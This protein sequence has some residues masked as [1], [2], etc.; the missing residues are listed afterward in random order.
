MPSRR[1]LLKAGGVL[2]AATIVPG[3]TATQAEAAS[4]DP[5]RKV[6]DILRKIRPPR[7]PD[8]RWDVTAFGAVG[9]GT[10]DCTAAF[11]AAIAECHR[12]GGGRVV[13][14][15]GRFLTGAIHLLSD[16]E[17][18][19]S[20]GGVIAFSTDP[21][22]YLPVVLTRWESTECYNYSPFIYAYGR[23][24]VAVTGKG[25]LDGQARQ[26]PWESWYA[27]SGPQS[28]DQ[29]ALRKMGDDGV[30]VEQ[31]VFGAGHY[32]RPAMVQFVKC[33]N[34]LVSDVTILEP[35]MW[36]VNPVL[37]RN[38]TV[39]GITV[40]STLYN[41][42][43]CDPEASSYV[44][45]KDCRFNTNDDC[46]AVKSGRDAD[47]RRVGV[48]S[49]N[50]VVQDCYFSGRWGGI[51][52][53]SEMSGGVRNVFAER[54]VINSP[55]FPGNYPVKY[56]VYLKA[57]KKRGAYIEGVYVR[58]FTGGN[59]EREVIFVN[60]AYNNEAGAEPLSVRDIRMERT[61][62]DGAGAVLNLVGLETDHLVDVRLEKCE[63]TNVAGPDKIAFTDGLRLRKV[64]VN[65]V[66]Q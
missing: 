38:V 8:R 23:R 47:G 51:T 57:N 36:T 35:P 9:D 24:N 46:V 54:C 17:L 14:P 1:S 27:N 18:H 33:Q 62:L 60:M 50:I 26:G 44:H 25:T 19:V 37:S 11:K 29:K 22:A 15:P 56:P 63:F 53:G 3:T 31:R 30:P 42:D 45:I 6:P 52:V 10:T 34:I 16:V 61:R 32:L 5:W 4:S 39:R 66:E 13:V 28:A 55:D 40:V 20:E 49:E 43:G 59:V 12:R 2:A 64:F 7:F 65:G 21:N 58:D 48:P 41:T